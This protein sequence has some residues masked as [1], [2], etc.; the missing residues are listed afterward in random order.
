MHRSLALACVL[1]L[2]GLAPLTALSR[3]DFD[4]VV[5]F[6]LTLKNLAAVADGREPL[7]GGRLLLLS[8]TVSD[9]NIVSKDEANFKVRIELIAGEWIGLDDVKSY[10]C[11]VDFTGPEYF[12]VF[13]ARAPRTTTPG[14]VT[15]NARVVVIGSAVEVTR[16]PLG[17][18]RV[19]VQGVHIRVIE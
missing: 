13:P 16:T 15:L 12:K 1:F 2:L 5:D 3:A 9:V 4:R 6:S 18:K 8:G 7:P 14:T 17:E 19:L 11:Y 10:A